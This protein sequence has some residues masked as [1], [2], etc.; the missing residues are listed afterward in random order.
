MDQRVNTHSLRGESPPS[1]SDILARSSFQRL[2]G[3]S[4]DNRLVPMYY[5]QKRKLRIAS[6]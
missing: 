6:S 4:L 2:R 1:A 5:D 3:A